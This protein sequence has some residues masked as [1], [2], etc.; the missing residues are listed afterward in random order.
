M[1]NLIF[2][3]FVMGTCALSA[4][5]SFVGDCA[6]NLTSAQSKTLSAVFSVVGEK[7]GP[8]EAICTAVEERLRLKT[9]LDLSSKG[10]SDLSV[11]SQMPW[12]AAVNLAG[13]QVADLS[14]LEGLRDLKVLVLSANKITGLGSLADLKA[15]EYLDL[16]QNRIS[17]V[18]PLVSLPALK[19]LNLSENQIRDVS[20]LGMISS[21]ET[22]TLGKNAI[23]ELAPLQALINLRLLSVPFNPVRGF[24]SLQHL[25][26]QHLNS[27]GEWNQLQ[28]LG[29]PVVRPSSSSPCYPAYAASPCRSCSC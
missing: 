11:L 22:L 19:N 13:N 1:K 27:A 25:E 4:H 20:P 9:T 14:A 21:L 24:S 17:D 15:I 26:K 6:A 8:S 29:K 7:A 10:I 18:S 2:S 23:S 3:I 12:L 16:A 28:I 5:G